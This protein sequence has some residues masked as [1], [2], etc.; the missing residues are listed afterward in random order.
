MLKFVKDVYG[1]IFWKVALS[2]L[3][4]CAFKDNKKNIQATHEN[5]EAVATTG[6]PVE[7]EVS[8]KG[9]SSI[10]TPKTVKKRF[11]HQKFGKGMDGSD[12]E[13]G[14]GSSS[15]VSPKVTATGLSLEDTLSPKT[16][17]KVRVNRIHK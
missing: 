15:G 4:D 17:R 9:S 14:A 16:K 12:V 6:R 11:F 2:G 8:F 5:K 1:G 3:R 7:R 10:V 13:G